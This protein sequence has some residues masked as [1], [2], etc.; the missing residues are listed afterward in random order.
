MAILLVEQYYDFARSLADHYLVMERGEIIKR[1]DGIDI[2]RRLEFAGIDE[3]ALASIRMLKP[4]I[5]RTMPDALDST[6]LEA[7]HQ[8]AE[9]RESRH[10]SHAGLNAR[11]T[12][13]RQCKPSPAADSRRRELMIDLELALG[14]PSPAS[15][16]GAR[17]AR[18]MLL[19]SQTLKNR[20]T[21]R[22][23]QELFLELCATPGAVDG[24]RL[25][26]IVGKL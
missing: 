8:L 1:G 24:A 10:A 17:R 23:P 25:A 9:K 26:A 6:R 20:A 5:D 3:A 2:D 19:L 12:A 16:D 15:D 13:V 4:C 21:K 7:V 11:L 14:L 22:D 18:Q